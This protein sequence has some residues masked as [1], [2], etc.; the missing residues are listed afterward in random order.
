M[1]NL[2]KLFALALLVLS[3]TSIANAQQSG[4]E[5]TD[6]VC[7]IGPTTKAFGGSQWLVYSCSDRRTVV[8]MSVPG[9]AAAPFY[10]VL[11]PSETGYRLGGEGT[12]NQEL[13]A[14]AFNELQALSATDIET[15]IQ[16][17][18]RR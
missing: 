10:F 1:T 9:N 5:P 4:T 16:E 11:H 17:T 3:Q 14:A 6:L 13:T 8:V 12:G 7:D 15:L 2:A 18:R